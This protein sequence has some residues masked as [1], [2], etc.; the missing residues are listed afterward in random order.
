M[1]CAL[2]LVSPQTLTTVHCDTWKEDYTEEIVICYQL[3]IDEVCTDPSQSP[4][5]H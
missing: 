5:Y 2:S 4:D 3:M 1:R